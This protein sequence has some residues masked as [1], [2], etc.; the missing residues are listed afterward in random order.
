LT[1]QQKRKGDF[2]YSKV[3]PKG[4]SNTKRSSRKTIK[5]T[6]KFNTTKKKTINNTIKKEGGKR[7][8][9]FDSL[10]VALGALI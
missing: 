3:A 2:N 10:K 8:G 5:K 7:G 6:S 9:W 4:I 1:T